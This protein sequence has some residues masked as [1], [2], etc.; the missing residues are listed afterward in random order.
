MSH[1]SE[2]ELTI[3]AERERNRS[4][5]PLTSWESISA[6]LREEGVIREGNTPRRSGNQWML[7]AAAAVILV[8]GGA[9]AGRYTTKGSQASS[10]TA[11]SQAAG[12]SLT[13]V[14]D[15]AAPGFASETEAWDV[16]NR[17]GAEYQRASEYLASRDA[18]RPMDSTSVYQARLAALDGMTSAS[19]KALYAA[20][21]DPVINQ[22]YL[23]AQ[24]ARE[25]TIRQLGNTLPTGVKLDKW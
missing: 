22:Y 10:Q 15:K 24:G 9:V 14:S 17:S 2:E 5:L 13:Q 7:R 18:N 25:A 16:L 8:A 1:L 3:L 23:A 6:Q 19:R 21:H 12:S 4:Q 20:P 11:A